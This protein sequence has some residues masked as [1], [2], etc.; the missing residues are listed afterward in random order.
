VLICWRRAESIATWYSGLPVSL[1]CL[2]KASTRDRSTF[3]LFLYEGL[4]VCVY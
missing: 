3:S 2:A 1:S 4:D